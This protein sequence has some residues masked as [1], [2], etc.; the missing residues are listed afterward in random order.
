MSNACVTNKHPEQS[1]CLHTDSVIE[2]PP[3]MAECYTVLAD[4]AQLHQV[5]LSGSWEQS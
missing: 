2:T 5:L 1:L 4:A 3:T